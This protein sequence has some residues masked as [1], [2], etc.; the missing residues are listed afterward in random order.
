MP[1][2]R[3][4]R[5]LFFSFLAVIVIC[6]LASTWFASKALEDAYTAAAGERLQIAARMVAENASSGFAAEPGDLVQTASRVGR[7]MG[8]RITLVR[9]DG[10]VLAD[11]REDAAKMENHG[12]RPEISAALQGNE[13]RIARFSTT[14]GERMLYVATPVRAGHQIVGV[15]RAAIGMSE[16]DQEFARTRNSIIG[17]A[18]IVGL[19]CG[20]IGW[21]LAQR[22]A[23][24]VGE[25]SEG[26]RRIARGDLREKLAVPDIDELAALAES[27]NQLAGQL[28]ER[29]HAIGRKGHEQEAVLASMAEGVLAVDSDERVISLNRAA[30]TLIGGKQTDMRGRNLQEVV[31]NADLRRFASR[32]LVSAEPIEDDLVLIGDREKILH[33]RGTA[34]RDSDGRGVGAVIVLGDVTEFRLLERLRRDFVANVSHELKTPIASIKGF[35]ETLLDGALEHR[36]DAVRFLRIVAGQAD[37]LNSI[38]ED[39]LSLSKIERSEE[40]ADLPL[41]PTGV[42]SVLEAAINDC[43]SKATERRIEVR[44]ACDDRIQATA[45]SPLLEQAVVNLLDNAI[46]Y[47]EPGSAVRIVAEKSPAEVTIAVVDQGCG[48]EPEHLPRLFERFYRVD[49]ARSRKLGGTGLGLAIVKHIV[50]A[51]HGRI[52]VESSFGAGSTFTIH[53]PAGTSGFPA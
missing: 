37:R 35:V 28:E 47:S 6:V 26:A 21:W 22:L 41:E 45:N 3:L 40:A 1:R 25:L 18:C 49:R 50:Q 36:D 43:Q 9:P 34:L 13:E 30:A 32:A 16:I 12:Q 7:A 53:L 46:K 48:I 4:L 44:L 52:T 27:L 42:K 8:V 39:L 14:L 33:V 11:N 10:S 15:V 38:I 20:V 31:R 19:S 23:Q 24:P 17:A 5:Q 2:K 29:G 51:H